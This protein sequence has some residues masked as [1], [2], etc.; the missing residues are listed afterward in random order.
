[1]STPAAAFNARIA[2]LRARLADHGLSPDEDEVEALAAM[3][4]VFHAALMALRTLTAGPG[5]APLE[6]II[7]A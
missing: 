6:D 4:A 1:M 3:E 7:D 2:M 5:G